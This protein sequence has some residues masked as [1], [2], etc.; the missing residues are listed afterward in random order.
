M[1]S[2]IRHAY[3]K[4]I[5]T[6]SF[7]DT[8]PTPDELPSGTCAPGASPGVL[9]RLTADVRSLCP[10]E[11]I[12]TTEVDQGKCVRCARCLHHGLFGSAGTSG[13][14]GVRDALHW[15][16]GH[17]PAD[18]PR[19]DPPLATLARSVHVFLIDVGSCQGCNLEV[20]GLSNPYYDLNRLGL[21][22]TNSPRHADVLVVVGVP[23]PAMVEPLR[24]TFEAMPSPKAVLAVGACA[25]D[26][27]VFAGAP[28]LR[29]PV[30]R[31][32]PVDLYVAGCP[33]PPVA[34]LEGLIRLARGPV[35]ASAE[36][37]P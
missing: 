8:P 37:R 23:T 14:V 35:G 12:T 30:S 32:I 33:P 4:G 11:A 36:V 13:T 21:F 6:T 34:I 15:P 9:S 17:P 18:P 10:T 27:G 31:V 22:F 19:P 5:V 7:P 29:S 25:I 2:W 26:G 1:T 20:L 28:A 16:D 3:S 24:R